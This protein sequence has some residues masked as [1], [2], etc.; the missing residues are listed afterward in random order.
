MPAKPWSDLAPVADAPEPQRPASRAPAAPRPPPPAK[1]VSP[2]Y[3]EP[4]A[5][6]V[7]RHIA[8][9]RSLRAIAEL[10]H[11]PDVRTLWRWRRDHKDF[12]EGYDAARELL[13]E[14]LA[15]EVLEIADDARNDWMETEYGPRLDAE[16]VRR[17]QVRIE[18]RLK[19]MGKLAP[20]RWGEKA[21]MEVKM[22][23]E[24]LILGSLT[25]EADAAALK[26]IEGRAT[27]IDDGSR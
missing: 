23:L 10:P 5:E 24:A 2:N 15:G 8:E 25:P 12:R 18:T 3:S 20:A 11:M 26:L 9:G 4:L 13:A 27:V 21:S 17:S 16:H 19:L 22:T 14:R 7:C 1:L 6:E